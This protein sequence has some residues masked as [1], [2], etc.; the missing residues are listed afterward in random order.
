MPF[1]GQKRPWQGAAPV[2]L[3]WAGLTRPG[4]A[5]LGGDGAT[6]VRLGWA[7]L[8]RPGAALVAAAAAGLCRYF[9]SVVL[10]ARMRTATSAAGSSVRRE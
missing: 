6:P 10:S 5:R 1:K 3:G 9:T 8:A 2:R 4:A 7:G